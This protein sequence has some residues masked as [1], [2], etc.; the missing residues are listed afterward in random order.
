MLGLLYFGRLEKEKW[1]DG[2]IDMIELFG[3]KNKELPFQIFIFG[4]WSRKNK[5]QELAQKYNNIHFFWRQSLETI[6]RYIPNC[7]YCLIPSECLE[8]FWLSALTAIKLWL[9]PI[10]YA[11]WWLKDF[12][13]NELDLT[14]QPWTTTG[15]KLHHLIWQLQASS[16]K[17]QAINLH[18]YSKEYRLVRF[19]GLAGK[20]VK[21][22]LIVSDFI[23]RIWWIETYI[24]DVKELL[25]HHG[26]QVELCGWTVPSWPLGKFVKYLWIITGLG[27]FWE[28]IKLQRK[29]KRLQPD[30]IRYNSVMR[31]LGRAA[32]Q[33]SKYSSAKKR[34]MFHDLGYFYP[35][36]SQLTSEQQIKTPCTLKHFLSS[37]STKNPVKKL[38]IVGK[39]ALLCLIKK[40]LQKRMD[41]FLVPSDFMKDIVHKSYNIDNE[42]INIFPHFIQE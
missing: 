35:F 9:P 28:A 16:F 5:I 14:N 24:N 4:T 25:E 27:N 29:I 39:Y 36:P 18:E 32:V 30:L 26:Y 23:N 40:Q 15:K 11:K 1:I 3:E 20:N 42:K 10:G 7:N 19:H 41:L 13:S 6:K 12:I 21:K 22:V 31:Y 33:I 37:Y 34:M 2:I 17:L 8:T 38:A